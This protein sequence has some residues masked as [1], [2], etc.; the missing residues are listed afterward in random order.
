VIVYREQR[1]V[2]GPAEALRALGRRVEGLPSRPDHDEVVG[3]LVDLGVLEAG[4]ADAL[5]PT[6]DGDEALGRELRRASVAAGHLVAASWRREEAGRWRDVLGRRLDALAVL[7]L[8]EHVEVR[9]PEGFAQYGH[10]PECHLAAAERLFRELRPPSAI[11]IGIR[12]IGT[13]LSAVVAA[14]LEDAGCLVS[15]YTVRPR[16][17]PFDRRPALSDSLRA[18]LAASAGAL[19]LLV[20]EGPGLSGSSLAGTAES[21]SALGIADDRIVL[22]PSWDPA[23]ETLRSAV[24]R[25]RWCRHRRYVSTFEEVWIDSGRLHDAL[26]SAPVRD[27]SAGR[28]REE[29]IAETVRRPPVHPHHERRKYRSRGT[30]MR[31]VGL[32]GVAQA[33]LARARDLADSGFSPR[34]SGLAHG[35]LS[36]ELVP[37]VPLA[38]GEVDGELLERMA[39]YL[40]HLRGTFALSGSARTELGEMI[41]ANLAGLPG[42]SRAT[43]LAPFGDEPPVAVDGRMMPHEWLRTPGGYLKVDALDHHDDH[44]FP[45]PVDI[46]W[47][48]AGAIVEFDMA[49]DA[50][51]ALVER[52]RRASG[53]RTIAKRLPYYTAAYLAA[54]IGYTSLAAETLHGSADGEG[55][56]RSRRRYAAALTS[57]AL[58]S[59]RRTRSA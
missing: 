17:H 45:G 49:P 7:G 30:L 9:V 13:A 4:I 47:D 57:G 21:L 34:P 28:W 14:C 23:P 33:R 37:G 10:F 3:L 16:G 20:D 46:A 27:L 56:A 8:P 18:T 35:F 11:C 43:R 54:R 5:A 32:G 39:C 2:T 15:S 31:F 52:Y 26:G 50:R 51:G 42:A 12:S 19:F 53:D 40:A 58:E 25:R 6:E 48:L 38:R 44:F 22:L 55:F 29:L 59:P 36:R 41:E 24:A 1:S